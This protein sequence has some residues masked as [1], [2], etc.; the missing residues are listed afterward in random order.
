MKVDVEDERLVGLERGFLR[1][2]FKNILIFSFSLPQ[3]REAKR[4]SR[5]LRAIRE[6]PL[7]KFCDAWIETPILQSRGV[8]DTSS[9]GF[10]ATFSSRRRLRSTTWGRPYFM[11]SVREIQT[12]KPFALRVSTARHFILSEGRSPKSKFCE[13]KIAAGEISAL[14]SK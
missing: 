3:Q 7:Q 14:R 13:S 12:A 11:F 1:R 10:A 4:N 2:F 9:V 6:S 5:I 8:Q